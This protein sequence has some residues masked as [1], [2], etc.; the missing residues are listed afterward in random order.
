M[1]SGLTLWEELQ[2][3]YQ[4]GVDEV[5]DFARIW[6]DVKPSIDLQR[7]QEVNERLRQQQLDA[8]E[9]QQVCMSYLS[10]FQL[11]KK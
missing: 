11:K 8:R 3:H 4:R 5:D 6:N 1:C 9:W 7:W 10:T 2:R